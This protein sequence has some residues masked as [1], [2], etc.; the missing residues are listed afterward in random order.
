[1]QENKLSSIQRAAASLLASVVSLICPGVFPI[2]GREEAVGFSYDFVFTK[3]FSKDLFPFLEQT[4]KGFVGKNIKIKMLEMMPKNACDFFRYKKRY[5]P[6]FFAKQTTE[7][8]VSIFQMGDFVDLTIPPYPDTTLEI[9]KVKLDSISKRPPIIFRKNQHEVTRIYGCAFPQLKF[10]NKSITIKEAREKN[11]HRFIGEEIGLFTI[12]KERA[13]DCH[14]KHSCFWHGKGEEVLYQLSALW[15]R[16]YLKRNFELILGGDFS[17]YI[18]E[19]SRFAKLGVPVLNGGVDPLY[20]LH[21]ATDSLPDRAWT[22]CLESKILD[23]IIYFLSFAH[24]IPK[25]FHLDAELVCLGK[26]THILDLFKKAASSLKIKA[27]GE[28]G[29][30][31]NK[32]YYEI[33]DCFDRN[34]KGPWIKVDRKKGELTCLTESIYGTLQGIIALFLE[35]GQKD[36]SQIKDVLS[37]IKNFNF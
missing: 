30:A 28:D 18:Q 29:S 17:P 32:M 6:S 9:G 23:E 16:C 1:M 8:L 37:R 4:I 27:R 10:S 21:K 13:S 11:D 33:K 7:P 31:E 5:Y 34:W 36:L 26:N 3:P 25:L 15:R 24:K 14:E 35:S 19:N 12:Q 22:F 2:E 20:G